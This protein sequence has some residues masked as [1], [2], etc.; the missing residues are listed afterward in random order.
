MRYYDFIKEKYSL[1]VDIFDT[2]KYPKNFYSKDNP[3]DINVNQYEVNL[4]ENKLNKALD[5]IQIIPNVFIIES[6]S[7]KNKWLE[8]LKPVFGNNHFF[9]I[10][11]DLN[12]NTGW[13]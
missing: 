7:N 6:T 3:L 10:A 2:R 9:L 12:N 1:I 11:I 8:R 5:W 4:F 13:L